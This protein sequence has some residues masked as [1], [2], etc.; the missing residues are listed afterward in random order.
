MKKMKRILLLLLSMTMI[1]TMFSVISVISSAEN[2]DGL[3][4][5][6][7]NGKVVIIDF[8]PRIS[9]EFVI[10]DTIEGHPVIAIDEEAFA[11]CSLLKSVTIPNSV[12]SIG[13]CAFLE[14]QALTTVLIPDGV[15]E[16]GWAT[17]QSCSS[18][19]T[20]TIPDSVTYIDGYAFRG[21]NALITVNYTGTQEQW[22]AINIISDGNESLFYVDIT[23]NAKTPKHDNYENGMNESP[24]YANH[25]NNDIDNGSY[26]SGNLISTGAMIGIVIIL[27]AAIATVFAFWY[28]LKR[29]N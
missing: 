3:W 28:L 21:C 24:D 20:V 13:D 7:A 12:V 26:N 25:E 8:D 2:V 10:P 15:K 18:L 16:I 14:C 29:K 6:I 9:G 1:L 11:R 17:F 23:F 4:Y 22:N 5:K 27:I 19:T